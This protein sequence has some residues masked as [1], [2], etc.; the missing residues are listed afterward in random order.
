MIPGL[1]PRQRLHDLTVRID[2]GADSRWR[3]ADDR[4]ALF[5]RAKPCLG[6]ML[7]RTPGAEPGVVGR[8]EDEVRPVAAIDDLAGEDDLVAKLET[9]LA[10]VRQGDGPRTRAGDEIHV[11]GCKPRQADCRQKRPHRQI[12]AVGDEMRLVVAA[13]QPARPGRRRTRCSRR[14]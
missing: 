10:P 1:A 6:E 4:Y 9:D 7:R 14:W 3:R 11:A 5:R 8:V 2:D 13:E 12:F